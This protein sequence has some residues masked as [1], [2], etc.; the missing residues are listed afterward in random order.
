MHLDPRNLAQQQHILHQADFLLIPLFAP[1]PMHS[2]HICQQHLLFHEPIPQ[3]AN[4]L[5]EGLFLA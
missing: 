5:Q 2:V 4:H 3:L 1:I